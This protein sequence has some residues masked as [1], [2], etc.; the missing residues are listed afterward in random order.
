MEHYV[1]S[2]PTVNLTIED[3]ALIMDNCFSNLFVTDARGKIIYVN[4]DS[5]NALGCP[6]DKLL[7]MDVYELQAQGYTSKSITA[8]AIKAGER[9]VG[10]YFNR[11]GKEIGT[12]S[13]PVCD[14]AGRV[15]MIVTYSN[16]MDM[17]ETFKEEL[18]NAKR[19]VSKFKAA[20]N[21]VDR[22]TSTQVIAEDPA[23]CSIF[24]SLE[25]IA[26]SDSSVMLYGESGVGKEIVAN[27]IQQHSNRS[28]ELFIPINCAAIP[29]ELI[30]AELFG[31]EKNAFTG[32]GKD[33]KPGLF[34]LADG[35]TIFLD[36]LGEL[37]LLAQAKLLRALESGECRRVGGRK[38]YKV[39]VRIIGAT[40]RD[41]KRMMTQK[42]FRNDL[43]YRL[44][45]L[46]V[47]IPPLR[48]RPHDL[49]ALTEFFL[50]AFNRKHGTERVI[51][52]PMLIAMKNYTW[53]GNIRELRNVIERY[54]ITG[55]GRALLVEGVNGDSVPAEAAAT[56]SV[57]F[58][59]AVL[60]DRPLKEVINEAEK[61]YIEAA[62]Q[63]CGG[64]VTRTARL[65]GIHRSVLYK[66]LK[67]L[68][69][70]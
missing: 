5:A 6:V 16:E 12:V 47:V 19:E 24:N 13:T 30:E 27:F 2:I 3:C 66:K 23:M 55:D 32:A 31:Y 21:F 53:P 1:T 42:E 15:R 39:D 52:Q 9:T 64:E 67:K 41:L 4:A 33:G 36:E 63:A 18:R 35:G 48:E 34:E 40:N 56:Q 7:S 11:F 59:D 68:G 10:T 26:R 70:A 25:S 69:I 62:L 65:L 37:P 22:S 49:E 60:S 46:P 8:E 58:T 28:S 20:F 38:V 45:V 61:R 43:Y 57:A 29:A 44:N 51:T 14:D 17:L 50:A 54:V